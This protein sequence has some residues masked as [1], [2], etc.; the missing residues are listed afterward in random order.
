MDDYKRKIKKQMCHFDYNM[1]KIIEK[2]VG[3]NKELVK[4]FEFNKY[5]GVPSLTAD[6]YKELHDK[7]NGDI[8]F[9]GPKGIVILMRMGERLYIFGCKT[10]VPK[11]DEPLFLLYNE[12]PTVPVIME[13]TGGTREETI[14]D[15][16]DIIGSSIEGLTQK[17]EF[18]R[19]IYKDA[20]KVEVGDVEKVFDKKIGLEDKFFIDIDK[21]TVVG[22]LNRAVLAY[23]MAKGRE[24]KYDMSE[25]A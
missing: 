14:G 8:S 2:R 11:P 23:L 16:E 17:I 9:E 5:N 19:K 6:E 25:V 13:I 4:D 22:T 24:H 18:M 15:L 12:I 10:T 21:D 7:L 1:V 20:S 3:R